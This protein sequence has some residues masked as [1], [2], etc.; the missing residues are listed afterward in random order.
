MAG[1]MAAAAASIVGSPGTLT[2]RSTSIPAR[3]SAPML[4][5]TP[6][7]RSSKPASTITSAR[8]AAWLS[9]TSASLRATRRRTGGEQ[10]GD[11]ET[12]TRLRTR[13]PHL[14]LRILRGD[15]RGGDSTVDQK[16]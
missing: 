1:V 5:A 16:I 8:R 13:S 12:T 9:T 7:L 14:L 2:Y 15:I 11:C 4:S 3:R 10:A 6:L